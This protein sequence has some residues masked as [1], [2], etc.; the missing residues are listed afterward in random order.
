MKKSEYTYIKAKLDNAP[1]IRLF[2][3]EGRLALEKGKANDAEEIYK[4]LL[5]PIVKTAKPDEVLIEI[6]N[7]LAIINALYNGR[8]DRAVSYFN[9]GIK[10]SLQ[11]KQYEKHLVTLHTNLGYLYSTE[12]HWDDALNSYTLALSVAMATSNGD[13][14][15]V[16][17]IQQ[18]ISDS[19]AAKSLTIKTLSTIEDDTLPLEDAFSRLREK[20]H[21]FAS[22]NEWKSAE[23]AF[24]LALEKANELENPLYKAILQ[25]DL[26][27]I[28]MEKGAIDEAITAFTASINV[29]NN[30]GEKKTVAIGYNNL[31]LLYK[32]QKQY[33][34]A[35]ENY[36]ESVK[37]KRELKDIKS[38][39]NTLYNI[40][41]LYFE[42][43]VYDEALSYIQE[44]VE[45]DKS[46]DDAQYRQS[47]ALLTKIR[48]A[49]SQ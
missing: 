14:V 30:I 31:G 48:R 7:S 23:D 5:I 49:K 39:S 2:I 17:R 32:N 26:G 45:L 37:I 21:I 22:I 8:H 28:Y 12:N 24:S 11:K 10:V 4:S 36:L 42:M 20:G 29:C 6:L 25:I 19:L 38:L 41:S 27:S 3:E 9:D 34:K 47:L 46:N 43:R 44:A 18:K 15:A 40:A 35:V 13:N 16:T 1:E 33:E